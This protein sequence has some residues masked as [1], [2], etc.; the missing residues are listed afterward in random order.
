MTNKP[1]TNK[2]RGDMYSFNIDSYGTKKA[3]L[4]SRISL[5]ERLKIN[6]IIKRYKQ[7][8]QPNISEDED[9]LISGFAGLFQ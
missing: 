6:D 9:D 3:D 1:Q 5:N 4:K 8:P 2:R 7:T